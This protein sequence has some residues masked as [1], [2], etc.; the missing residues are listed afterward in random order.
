MAGLLDRVAAKELVVRARALAVDLL[1]G[2]AQTRRMSS[3]NASA[4]SPS[5]E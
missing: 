1:G 4:T 3:M 5:P 2:G